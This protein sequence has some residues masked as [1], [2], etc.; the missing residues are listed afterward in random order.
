MMIEPRCR[1]GGVGVLCGAGGP[2]RIGDLVMVPV[3]DLR[4]ARRVGLVRPHS[5]TRL[6]GFGPQGLELV[7]EFL[8]HLCPRFLEPLRLD[9]WIDDLGGALVV[10]PSWCGPVGG[11]GTVA[12]DLPGSAGLHLMVTRA[13]Q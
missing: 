3:V 10:L 12:T 7:A 6:E 11:A 5:S 8:G 2:W 9:L 13:Q 1:L 4:V